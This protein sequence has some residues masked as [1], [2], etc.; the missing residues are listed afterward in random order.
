MKRALLVAMLVGVALVAF[1]AP[2]ASSS[3]DG[4]EK[5]SADEGFDT[6]TAHDL[7]D[8]PLADYAVDGVDN[9]G[10]ST[11]LAGTLGVLVTFAIGAGLFYVTRHKRLTR[12]ARSRHE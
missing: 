11:A 10:M 1:V 12:T 2:F 5:V 3:P 7:A 6:G 8:G 9:E 4:L